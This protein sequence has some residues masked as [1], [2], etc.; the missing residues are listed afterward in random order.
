M[1]VKDEGT[2]KVDAFLIEFRGRSP[3]YV[4]LRNKAKD[5][6]IPRL[7]RPG[8]LVKLEVISSLKHTSSM[9]PML[10][11]EYLVKLEAVS[12]RRFGQ[13]GG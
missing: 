5:D 1:K 11:L 9:K 10:R 4:G 12:S 6:N 13:E 7:F 2:L 8:D 3:A